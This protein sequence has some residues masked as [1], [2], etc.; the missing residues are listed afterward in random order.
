V[1]K[2]IVALSAAAV[3]AVPSAALAAGGLSSVAVANQPG[4]SCFGNFR[5]GTVDAFHD[6]ASDWA[7]GGGFLAGTDDKVHMNDYNA[8]GKAYC[9]AQK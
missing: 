6:V 8:W 7:Q 1:R 3:L 4:N 2:F 5:A 9:A